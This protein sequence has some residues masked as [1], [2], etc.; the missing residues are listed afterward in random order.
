MVYETLRFAETELYNDVGAFYSSLDADS[1]NE[2]GELE[3][4]A[5]YVWTKEELEKLLASDFELFSD[6]YNVNDNGKWEKDKY[7]LIR[8]Q[9]DADFIKKHGINPE[10]LNKRLTTWKELLLQERNERP[11]P[12]LDDK[13]LTSWNA[14]MLKGY[15]DA[16]MTFNDEKFLTMALKN[17]HFLIN[18]Q[19]KE[20]GGLY[21]N[22]KNGKST[23]EAYLE[24][25]ATLID[26]YLS[27]LRGDPR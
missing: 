13:T 1:N 20:D 15:V 19:F 27:A 14:L 4:G 25:Y 9:S 12:R 18:R 24:D 26:A 23:I 7:H 5:F 8:T 2:A 10:Q 21:R 11:K 16:Y 17:A 22:Y 3:E 6:Y